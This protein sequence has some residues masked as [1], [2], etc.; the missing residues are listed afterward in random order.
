M[1]VTLDMMR[2]NMISIAIVFIYSL[3]SWGLVTQKLANTT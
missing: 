1:M 2:I 3:C